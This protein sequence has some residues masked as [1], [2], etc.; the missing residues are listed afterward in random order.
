M[1]ISSQKNFND[2]VENEESIILTSS[3]EETSPTKTQK[4]E[5]PK[6]IEIGNAVAVSTPSISN[7]GPSLISEGDKKQSP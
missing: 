6:K 2:T 7:C 3:D 4:F 1:E 5:S